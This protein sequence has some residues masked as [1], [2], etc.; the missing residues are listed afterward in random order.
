VAGRRKA[1]PSA[2]PLS[3]VDWIQASEVASVAEAGKLKLLT[4]RK[5]LTREARI[6]LREAIRMPALTLLT[7]LAVLIYFQPRIT[8]GFPRV[9]AAVICRV[10]PILLQTL[11]NIRL[12]KRPSESTARSVFSAISGEKRLE[13]TSVRSLTI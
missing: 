8:R 3:A 2:G 13:T 4:A 9:G 6:H 10:N 7:Q 12:A 11:R 5:V 1:A